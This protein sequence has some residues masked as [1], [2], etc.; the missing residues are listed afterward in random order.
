MPV[1]RVSIY[2]IASPI[3]DYMSDFSISALRALERVKHVFVEE[4]SHFVTE[5]RRHNLLTSH[6]V[7]FLDEEG[8]RERASGLVE[9]RT[10]FAILACSGIPG[11]VD[12]GHEIVSHCLAEH[13]EAIEL[14]PLG[15]SSALDAALALAGIPVTQF[16]FMG[17][18]PESWSVSRSGAA[19]GVPMVF[20]VRGEAVRAFVEEIRRELPHVGAMAL[21]KD[22]RKKSRSVTFR[23]D[24]QLGSP[25]ELRDDPEADFVAIIGPR[26][27][28]PPQGF[29]D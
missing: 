15:M 18:Y 4:E 29:V 26:G 9:R 20:F 16:Q 25:Q 7:F 6:E 17:H 10:S 19:L 14:V 22:I 24:A 11:F 3:G 21:F 5:L 13:P 23:F 27:P 28:P 2:L 8:C 12:P 1:T